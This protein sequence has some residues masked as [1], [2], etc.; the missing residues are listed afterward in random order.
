MANSVIRFI[1]AE[2]GSI[3]LA[4]QETPAQVED[5][6]E[7]ARLGLMHLTLEGSGKPVTINRDAVAYWREASE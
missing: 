5:Q 6:W 3:S 1:G 4:V 2:E 7:A